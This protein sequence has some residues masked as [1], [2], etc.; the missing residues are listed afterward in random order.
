MIN[1]GN[2]IAVSEKQRHPFLDA[3]GRNHYVCS[4]SNSH[5]LFAQPAVILRA[6]LG[7]AFAK[8]LELVQRHKTLFGGA[9]LPVVPDSLKNFEK[10]QI[11]HSNNTLNKRSVKGVC[12]PARDAVEVVDPDPG[13]DQYHLP[14]RISSRSPSHLMRPR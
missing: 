13:I 5:S 11:P 10:D 8:Q 3:K 6:L 7:H 12:V 4:F 2:E 14:P 9:V 1:K